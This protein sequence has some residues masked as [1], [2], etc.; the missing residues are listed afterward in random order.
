MSRSDT[1]VRLPGQ[2]P[3]PAAA[4][5]TGAL[6]RTGYTLAANTAITSL[7]GFGFWIAA[8]RLYPP[9]AVG[10]GSAAVALMMLLSTVAQLNLM[11]GLASFLPG[12]GA[13][14]RGLVTVAYGVTAALSVVVVGVLLVLVATTGLR[15]A[16]LPSAS[17]GE[18]VWFAAAVASWTLFALQD[19]VLTGLHRAHWL[20]VENA[21]FGALKLALLVALAPLFPRTGVFLAWTAPLALLIVPVNVAV[22]GRL[23]R[24]A[25]HRAGAVLRPRTLARFVAGDYVGSLFSLTSTTLLP[26][27]VL[28]AL[29]AEAS[30][31]FAIAWTIAFALETVA[32]NFATSLTVQGAADGED[33]PQLT[34][35]TIA[36]TAALFAAAVPVL[37]VAAPWV[38]GVFG[39]A[40]VQGST[41]V[42]RLLAVGVVLRAVIAPS[43][44]V[45]RVQRR[46]GRIVAVEGL[47]GVTVVGSAVLLL[48]SLGLTGVGLAYALGQAL[49][50]AFLAPSLVRF[51][52]RPPQPQP[53][54]AAAGAGVP[55]SPS[56]PSSR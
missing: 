21:V 49:T 2:A 10:Y 48:P 28:A 19:G 37:L 17:M 40:Y 18:A 45:A 54:P 25:G 8:A 6:A 7:L 32:L 33:L 1:E 44:A 26:P 4:A 20:P 9:S 35:A 36:R 31:H 53:H 29:G 30:A 56:L 43:L 3:A 51:L 50:A 47:L 41:P 5:R 14:R 52:R 46:A 23:L 11:H 42:L 12:L 24:G 39:D 55:A 34:L 16:A 15:V 27:L 22:Y 38:L 13:Q